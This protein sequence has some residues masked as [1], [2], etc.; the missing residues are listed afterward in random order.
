MIT[1]IERGLVV[2]AVPNHDRDVTRSNEV[3][4][5]ELVIGTRRVTSGE[6]G[7]L[8]DQDVG[9]GLLHDLSAL[10]G[11]SRDCG[12]GAHDAG[13]LDRLD[14]FRDEIGL[15]RLAVRLFEDGVDR[16]LVRLRDLSDD[17]CGI[18]VSR[19]NSVEVEDRHRAELTHLDCEVDVDHAI[20]RGAPEREGQMEV[21]AHRESDVDL[22]G[23]E[24]YAPGHERHFVESVRAAR[25]PA[26]PDLEAR[27]LPGKCFTGFDLA[28]FQGVFTPMVGGVR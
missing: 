7:A 6:D 19:V 28:L 22:F 2:D 13:C 3:F 17:R 10:L 12:N 18:F 26:N 11:A 4:E 24:C 15:D 27:L 8:D 21:L 5:G 14:A 9:P 23:V 25:S 1:A 20:H 16:C